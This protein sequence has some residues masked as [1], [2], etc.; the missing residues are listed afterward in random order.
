M[1][2]SGK[3]DAVADKDIAATDAAA[4]EAAREMLAAATAAAA[5]EA[6]RGSLSMPVPPFADSQGGGA[7]GAVPAP[8][9]AGTPIS[10]AAAADLSPPPP[11]PI[12]SMC[13]KSMHP[14]TSRSAACAEARASASPSI[15][16]PVTQLDNTSAKEHERATVSRAS[17]TAISGEPGEPLIAQLRD[18]TI[19]GHSRRT[20]HAP[21]SAAPIPRMPVPQPRSATTLPRTSP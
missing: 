16:K 7:N 8:A 10:G 21:K 11:M 17:M 15:S 6:C 14:S 12:M 2:P 18:P 5:V 3:D 4:A 13:T 9:I 1:P 19:N 20:N